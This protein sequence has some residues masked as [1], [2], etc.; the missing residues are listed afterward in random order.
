MKL[1]LPMYSFARFSMLFLVLV[2]VA[3][4]SSKTDKAPLHSPGTL[5]EEDKPYLS[6]YGDVGS[7][8]IVLIGGDEEY[9]SEESLPQLARILS[10][11]F[12]FNCKV[13]LPQHPDNLGFVDP[14]YLHN[15]PGLES[16]A[17]A[18]LMIIATRFRDLPD[19]QMQHIDSYLKRGG[20]VMGLRTATHAFHVKDSTS[21][22][23]HYGNFYKG[24]MAEWHG[25]F[26][27]L[28]LGEKWI[29]HHGHHKQQ[30]TKGLLAP[31][32]ENHPILA[33]IESG[34]I[35][36]STDVYGVRLPLVGDATPLVLGQVMN[37]T[38]PFDE[39]DLNFG[40]RERDSIVATAAYGDRTYHPNDPMMPVA[41]VKSYQ[42]PDGRSGTAFTTTMGSSSDFLSEGF[43]RL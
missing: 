20:P 13:L 30:S 36:G 43:R 3:C 34:D 38:L 41:W 25:G 26:G 18:D 32:A 22:W 9:R 27:R 33:G 19:D 39:T 37:R 29:S 23:F 1:I 5:I 40:L 7:Q 16:L 35:W 4:S 42:V 10:T 14:N 12:G 15:I 17:E 31:D 8:N 6:Y 2:L 21:N 11:H 24:D 28:V